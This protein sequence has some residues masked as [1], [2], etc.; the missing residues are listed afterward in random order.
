MHRS[1]PSFFQASDVH[2]ATILD[3]II[4]IV[5]AA[6]ILG[7]YVAAKT[8]IEKKRE[9]KTVQE[10]SSKELLEDIASFLLPQPATRFRAES[11]GWI[12]G[13]DNRLD[14]LETCLKDINAKIDK[15]GTDTSPNDGVSSLPH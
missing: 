8:S 7:M 14:T 1:G 15:I 12:K 3:G 6:I 2:V 4:Y 10:K 5:A 13:V 9:M 11:A